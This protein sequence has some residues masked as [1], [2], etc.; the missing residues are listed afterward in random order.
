MEKIEFMTLLKE[1][2]SSL[3]TNEH[4]FNQTSSKGI[5]VNLNKFRNII[6]EYVAKNNFDEEKQQ[7][8]VA[9]VGNPEITLTYILDSIMHENEVTLCVSEN[10]FINDT[11]VTLVKEAMSKCGIKD[12]WITFNPEYN[13]RYIRDNVSMF[14][15]IVYVGDYFEYLRFKAFVNRDV[16][17]NNFGYI[18]LFIDKNKKQEEYKKIMEFSRNENV[19]I[20]VFDDID[21]FINESKDVDYAVI[22]VDDPKDINK[23]QKNLKSAELVVNSFPYDKYKFKINR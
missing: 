6:E 3:T 12:R 10:Q 16:E 14:S 1:V 11:V 4:L 23:V 20:E 21:D 22:F 18:K 2:E 17:Y 19:F 8:G 5:N 15:K 9:Y 7:I 13:E